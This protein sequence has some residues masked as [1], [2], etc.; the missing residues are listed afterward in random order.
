LG[1]AR[2]RVAALNSSSGTSIGFRISE[3]PWGM[4][5]GHSRDSFGIIRLCRR[6]PQNARLKHSRLYDYS[7]GHC[8]VSPKHLIWRPIRAR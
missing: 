6:N 7:A 1:V 5:I 4:F 3:P 8:C 2:V